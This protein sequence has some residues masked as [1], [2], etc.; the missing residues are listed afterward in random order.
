V[1]ALAPSTVHCTSESSVRPI[2]S[3]V[4]TTVTDVR[5]VSGHSL[6]SSSGHGEREV[7]RRRRRPLLEVVD[8]G[9]AWEEPRNEGVPGSAVAVTIHR[10]KGATT[11]LSDDI[12]N[13]ETGN[14]RGG[15]P[16]LR[17]KG[18]QL[19]GTYSTRPASRVWVPFDEG[20]YVGRGKLEP[21]E[22]Q[23]RQG[24]LS[25]SPRPGYRRSVSGPA[26]TH[27]WD[28]TSSRHRPGR[29]P[30]HDPRSG[31]A[32]QRALHKLSRRVPATRNEEH[33][34][35]LKQ[36][37]LDGGLQSGGR[38]DVVSRC[39]RRLHASAPP[40]WCV[41]LTGYPTSAT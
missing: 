25:L 9:E 34:G 40:R 30:R 32:W 24:H 3:T 20:L 13:Q 27:P 37:D 17:H 26:R 4:A 28:R 7:N 15:T 5:P 18:P 22:D 6:P 39:A 8:Q 12:P 2:T 19:P 11:G 35:H 1:T 36:L 41:C 10:H 38:R 29:P 14:P 16:V 21:E 23:G 31:R 33:A